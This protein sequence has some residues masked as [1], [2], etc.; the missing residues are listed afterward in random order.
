MERVTDLELAAWRSFIKSYGRI[1]ESIEHDLA[2][3]GRV[4]L[5]SYDVL[6]ALFEAPE[7]KLRLGDLTQKVVITKSG[8]T[9][10]L[11]RLE[12]EGLVVRE[13]SGEDRR[14]T[15][16]KLTS[17]GE[18]QLRKAWPVYAQG[19]KKYFAAN[20]SEEQINHLIQAFRTIQEGRD[21]IDSK[22]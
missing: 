21:H 16:A 18:L 10:L 7:H 6:I 2:E 12:R 8:V 1:I 5:T 17:E 22:L 9:R 4:P 20:L 19:I 3:H 11:D 13:K 14:G 15:Y